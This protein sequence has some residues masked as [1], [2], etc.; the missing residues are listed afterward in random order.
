M[1]DFNCKYLRRLILLISILLFN[2]NCLFQFSVFLVI[3]FLV[4][5]GIGIA[6]YLKHDELPGI[7]EAGFNNTM[8]D[9]TSSIEA[10]HAWALVQ[11]ELKCCGIRGASDWKPI[12]INNTVPASCCSQL[13]VHINQCSSEFASTIGCMPKLFNLLDSKSLLLGGVGI[14][15]AL[16][17]LVGVFFAC[18]LS[19][20]FRENYETV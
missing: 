13:P 9:Y 16:I 2:I 8:N 11:G 20:A 3:V 12:F 1:Y 14:G 10:Q 18:C 6:G 19:R 7:L 4:E 17:Q 15:I 5:I